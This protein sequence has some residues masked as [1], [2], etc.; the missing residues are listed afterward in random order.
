MPPPPALRRSRAGFTL[1]E[2]IMALTM[3]TLFFVPIM[4]LFS[5]S[6]SA[7]AESDKTTTAL[8]LG[9]EGVERVKNLRLTQDQIARQGSVWWP[10]KGQ[11]PLL[12]NK[13]LWRVERTATPGTD[14]LEITVRVYLYAADGAEEKV[15]ELKTL[16]ADPV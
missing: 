6:L 15:L 2:V 12:M 13:R 9:Q 5:T 1:I 11:S 7:L 14:P 3:I 10:D 8:A 16:I 4:E